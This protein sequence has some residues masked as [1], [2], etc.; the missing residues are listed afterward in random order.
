MLLI[1]N[2]TVYTP[3]ERIESGAILIEDGRIAAVRDARDAP[4]PAGAPVVDA[5]GLLACPGFI[6]LQFNGGFG[7]DFTDDPSSIWDVAAALPRYGVT[8][9][10]PTIITAPLEKTAA[11]QE[12]VT[13]KRPAGFTGA[14]PLGLHVEGPFLNPLKKGA[15]NPRHLRAPDAAAVAGWSPATGVRLAT[16]APELP[17]ALS[18]VGLLSDRGVLVSAGHSTA[19]FDQAKAGFDAGI[20]YGTHLFNAMPA[21]QHRDPGLP[22]ALLTDARVT[23]GLIADGIHTHPAIVSLVWQALGPRRLNLVTDA[24]AALGVPAGTHRLADFDVVV[25]ATSARL[26]DGTLAG[27]ILSLDQALRNLIAMTDCS[28]HDA[29]QTMTTTAARAIGVSDRGRLARGAVADVVLLS[30]DL[31]V[32]T[33]IAAGVVAYEAPVVAGRV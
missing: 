31:Q 4:R 20:R 33:T 12:V 3:E 24:M 8:A 15:H 5:S 11:A 22:G 30:P 27:S 1:T 9:F 26:A 17:G 6:D 25:D 32:R 29:L 14:E 2:A 19:T 23:V 18:L 10:L 28:L 21:L 7:H 16:L 13:R